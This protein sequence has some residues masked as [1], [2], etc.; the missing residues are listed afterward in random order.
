MRPHWNSSVRPAPTHT[1]R[2][3]A[4]HAG[5]KGITRVRKAPHGFEWPHSG[6][7]CALY[8]CTIGYIAVALQDAPPGTH[9]PARQTEQCRPSSA[10]H[11]LPPRYKRASTHSR[12]K[13]RAHGGRR[14]RQGGA[15]RRRRGRPR[16]SGW[17]WRSLR[18]RPSYLKP[19]RGCGLTP[20]L[21]KRTHGC[22]P[23]TLP[24]RPPRSSPRGRG[25]TGRR[26]G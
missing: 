1:C 5:S 4:P 9:D 14:K 13:A 10:A 6:R 20:L 11:P 18:R 3:V 2:F 7:V 21:L 22:R 8:S 12:P 24:S 15:C 23:P 16:R 17:P 25:G 26:P 19:T